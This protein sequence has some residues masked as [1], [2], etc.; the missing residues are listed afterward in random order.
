MKPDDLKAFALLSSLG[1][2][3]RAALADL[4]EERQI[5]DG[6][7]A[8]REGDEAEGLVLLARG[9]LNLKSKRLGGYVGSMTAPYHLGAA[10]LFALGKRE[11][12]AVA[13]GSCTLWGLSRSGIARLADDAPRTAYRLAEASLAELAGLT[14]PSLDVIIEDDTR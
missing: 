3:D 8:F 10:S 6:R 11:V 5:D 9:Q 2:E 7:S 12:T 4:L 14:R 1:E 13:E